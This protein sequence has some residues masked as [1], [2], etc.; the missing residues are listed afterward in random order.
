MGPTAAGKSDVALAIAARTPTEI[1]SVDSALVY[2][3]MDIGTA[4][5]DAATRARVRHHLIDIRD[6][7]DVYSAAAFLS[8]VRPALD[9]VLAR[10][11]L[12]IL[13]GGTMLYFKA[14]KDG[15][16]DLPRGSFDVRE[17]LKE[18]LAADGS[19]ALHQELARVD[20]VAAARIHANDP[21]RLVRALEVYRL[22]G[23]PI[24]TWWARAVVPP[25]ASRYT[26][27]EFALMPERSTL[28]TALE[29]RFD[30]MLEAG[31]VG[32]VERLIARG[33]APDLPALRA[34][35]YRQAIEHLLGQR[36]F[37]EM[38]TRAVAATRQLA[39]RQLTW[40]ARW[41]NVA[42][43]DPERTD[44]PAAILNSLGAARIVGRS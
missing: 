41:R 3:G 31:F 40:L 7:D 29:R 8:D 20:P 16:A 11:A 27:H 18:Q 33:F 44:A 26:L 12:P 13:V 21:Q 22:S 34:V 30:A 9:D 24:S 4:K 36:S 42:V 10:G 15:L 37:A 38:R 32:E 19:A 43:L 2:R 6:P 14:F 35:G 23:V 17:L 39:K 1:V 5:P 25:E 28:H